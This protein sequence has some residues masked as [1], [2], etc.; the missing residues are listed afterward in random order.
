MSVDGVVH[1]PD[2]LLETIITVLYSD[3][4]AREALAMKWKM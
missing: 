1:I 2:D 3:E 4:A